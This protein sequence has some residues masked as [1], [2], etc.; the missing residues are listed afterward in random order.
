M[1]APLTIIKPVTITSAML[2]SSTVPET[3]YA[4]WNSGTT[5]GPTDRV[6]LTSTHKVYQSAAA[7]NLNNNPATSPTLWTEVSPT[8]RWKVFDTSNSTQT[9]QGLNMSYTLRPGQSISALAALNVV[10]CFDVRIRITHPTLGTLY[11][12]TTQLLTL[13]ASGDYWEWC[14]G[15]RTAPPLLVA[16]DL[17]G[18]LG[19]DVIVDFTGTT[20]LAVGVLMVGDQKTLGEGVRQGARVGIQDYSRKETNQFG[21]TVLVQRAF[22][23][24]ASF[25]IPILAEFVDEA[26]DY[27]TSI[28][29]VP[30]LWIGSRRYNSTVIFGFFKEFD[31][32]IAYHAV[33]ECSISI[34]GMT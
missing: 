13:P 4:V 21:D 20:E 1:S 29:A 30:C 7:G 19:C 11:D 8:N 26:I 28:R 23:K 6:I 15:E 24:R 34:E 9:E 18:I 14:F 2:V 31:V 5:Y 10:G 25:D 32:N 27:L 16:T 22:A 12:Q 33:S 3:D 17:P